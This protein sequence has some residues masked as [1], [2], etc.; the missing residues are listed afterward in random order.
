M[1]WSADQC[2]ALEPDDSPRR[3]E[4]RE[5]VMRRAPTAAHLFGIEAP[6]RLRTAAP[7]GWHGLNPTILADGNGPLL[8]LERAVNY[9]GRP[10]V[11]GSVPIQ[12]RNFISRI[13]DSRSRE[14]RRPARHAMSGAYAL[15]VDD[16]RLY[17][18]RGEL[19]A[20]GATCEYN[21]VGRPEIV[22][23]HLTEDGE[24]IDEIRMIPPGPLM[25]QKN[26]MPVLGMGHTFMH[27]LLHVVS[28]DGDTVATPEPAFSAGHFRGGGQVVPWRDGF[29][30]I[31]H[32]AI[33]SNS[34]RLYTHRFVW[35]DSQ[36]CARRVTP[37]FCFRDRGVE[38]AAG[39]VA[40]DDDA[41]VSFGAN[42][43]ES[44]VAHFQA[45][46]IEAAMWEPN[47]ERVAA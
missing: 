18:S 5:T 9:T 37:P 15:G 11:G 2:T 3:I 26:W 27:C 38:F 10:V 33:L 47:F 43:C 17:L 45:T 14:V 4:A 32:E 13:G 21:T 20:I 29:L 42:D 40:S 6:F 46:A 35:L 1:I 41:V 25:A 34:E 23:L 12:S 31:I 22:R 16:L 28:G 8:L 24:I 36:L 30:A 39:L 19:W 44:W 7:Q